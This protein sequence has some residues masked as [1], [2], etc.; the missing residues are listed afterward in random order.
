[1]RPRLIV[2]AGPSGSGKSRSFP[3]EYFESQGIDYFNIDDRL[4][5]LNGGS[6]DQVSQP[7]RDQANR[8]LN[9]FVECHIAERKDMAFETTLRSMRSGKSSPGWF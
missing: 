1:M 6:F 7:L 9:H 8:D 3:R 5:E 4:R 2:V